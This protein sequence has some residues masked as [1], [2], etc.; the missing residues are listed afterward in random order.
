MFIVLSRLCAVFLIRPADKLCS[1][2]ASSAPVRQP[3]PCKD[4]KNL[5]EVQEMSYCNWCLQSTLVFSAQGNAEKWT[6]S[7][8][9][10]LKSDVEC[11]SAIWQHNP[12]SIFC[13]TCD[14]S[15][16]FPFLAPKT[17]VLYLKVKTYNNKSL[18]N[19]SFTL[20]QEFYYYFY[21]F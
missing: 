18:F 2:S 6:F 20:S 1:C 15:F 21:Y 4:K 14:A 13:V 17:N 10:L 8:C 19:P 12:R 9:H 3:R 7:Q 5:I 11:L 16:R